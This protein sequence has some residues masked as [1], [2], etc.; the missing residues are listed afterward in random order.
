MNIILRLKV[1]L[2]VQYNIIDWLKLGC[3]LLALPLGLDSILL[4][5]VTHFY[6]WAL[7]IEPFQWDFVIARS[8]VSTPMLI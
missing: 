2:I 4:K 5:H 7:I 1:L 6:E 3:D 8:L